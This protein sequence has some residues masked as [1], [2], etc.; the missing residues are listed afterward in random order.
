MIEMQKGLSRITADQARFL[1]T[2]A[3]IVR[4]VSTSTARTS[5]T[6]IGVSELF[7][8]LERRLEEVDT[9]SLPWTRAY[10]DL[11]QAEA[12]SIGHCSV[13][14]AV[15][16]SGGRLETLSVI[17]AVAPT[18][19]PNVDRRP[20][21]ASALRATL[22]IAATY[23]ISSLA[24]PALSTGRF[25][26]AHEQV[27]PLIMATIVD[28]LEREPHEIDLVRLVIYPHEG[29]QI[30]AAYEAALRTILGTQR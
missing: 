26:F 20:L 16:T 11:S 18:F 23:L 17:H 25:G 7:E 15:L 3:T 10:E 8:E 9:R 14:D 2:K 24:L 12:R 22:T 1:K 4:D 6:E 27:A 28:F 5:L 21:L 29:P 30:F 13:G 19:D